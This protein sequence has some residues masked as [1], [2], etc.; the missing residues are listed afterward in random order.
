M[1][2][3]TGLTKIGFDKQLFICRIF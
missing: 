2:P 3:T 1:N